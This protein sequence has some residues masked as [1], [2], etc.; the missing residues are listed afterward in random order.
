MHRFAFLI[1]KL[2]QVSMEIE[3]RV[4]SDGIIFSLQ[5]TFAILYKDASRS[6][7]GCHGLWGTFARLH[8]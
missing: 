8:L 4:R 6:I 5:F 1:R 7:E 3:R 2:G